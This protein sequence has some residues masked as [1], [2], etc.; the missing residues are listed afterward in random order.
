ML[1]LRYLATVV[2]AQLKIVTNARSLIVK[3]NVSRGSFNELL[4][5]YSPDLMLA[6]LVKCALG[7][8]NMSNISFCVFHAKSKVLLT[9][10]DHTGDIVVI[11]KRIN[12]F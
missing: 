1:R 2:D 9:Y 12:F 3:I 11:Y 8:H 10:E 6:F 5:S 7:F 4:S